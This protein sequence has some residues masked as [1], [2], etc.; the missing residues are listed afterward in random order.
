MRFHRIERILRGTDSLEITYGLA[1][2]EANLYWAITYEASHEDW[3]QLKGRSLEEFVTIYN[4]TMRKM[5]P[6][7]SEGKEDTPTSRTGGF[8]SPI[9]EALSAKPLTSTFF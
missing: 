2:E 4:S 7:S 1:N 5:H 6:S 9:S 8:A 3:I